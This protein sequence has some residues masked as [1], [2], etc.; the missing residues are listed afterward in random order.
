V[1]IGMKKFAMFTEGNINCK[2]LQHRRGISSLSTCTFGKDWKTNI[3]T[4]LG[5]E[6]FEFFKFIL[7]SS[8]GN[9]TTMLIS[10]N[11]NAIRWC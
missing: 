4:H 2:R 11:S 8:E 5:S 3:H 6:V 9:S 10:C 7:P 1:L